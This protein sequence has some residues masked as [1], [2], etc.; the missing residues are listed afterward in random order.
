M[1]ATAD[2]PDA[3]PQLLRENSYADREHGADHH[4]GHKHYREQSEVRHAGPLCLCAFLWLVAPR[5]GFS[6]WPIR[7][8]VQT[9]AMHARPSSA[10]DALPD[11]GQAR[12]ALPLANLFRL[13]ALAPDQIRRLQS[14]AEAVCRAD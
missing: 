4:I 1:E 12:P 9:A 5:I 14:D 13:P 11:R 7:L 3:G 8:I 6:A 10:A 2:G